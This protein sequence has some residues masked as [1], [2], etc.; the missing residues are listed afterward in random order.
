M[1]T[2]IR[3]RLPGTI[4][5]IVSDKVVSG[6]VINTGSWTGHFHHYHK[7]RSE[8]ESERRRPGVR[9]NQSHRSFD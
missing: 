1:S 7:F 2:S 3:N 9:D 4:D 6:I 5:K 8:D